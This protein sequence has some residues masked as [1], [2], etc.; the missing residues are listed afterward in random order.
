[1]S[2]GILFQNVE[3]NIIRSGIPDKSRNKDLFY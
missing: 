1:M 3:H 2:S